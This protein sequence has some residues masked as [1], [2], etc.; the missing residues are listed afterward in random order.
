MLSLDDPRWKTYRGGYRIEYDAS[1]RL[2]KLFAGEPPGPIFDELWS[3]L[4]H[5]DD[6]GEASYAAVPYLLE[7]AR[8]R[9]RLDWNVFGL[10]STI[11]LC[12]TLSDNPPMPVELKDAYFQAISQSPEIAFNHSF[13]DWDEYLLECVVTCAALARNQ[14]VFGRI[15][16][17]FSLEKARQWFRETHGYEPDYEW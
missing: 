4:H 7:Y 15:Y 14:R 13:K 11:E 6:V 10:I 12:R 5:Q 3:Q 8:T 1:I 2:R 17:E 9:P 16:S